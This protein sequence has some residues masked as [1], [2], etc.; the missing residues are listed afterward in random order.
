[1]AQNLEGRI[2]RKVMLKE[3][4][5]DIFALPIHDAPAVQLDQMCWACDALREAW[6]A[7]IEGI[8]EGAKTVVGATIAD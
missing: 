1:M 6:E 7:E 4:Q 2:L 8:R 5:E 3:L